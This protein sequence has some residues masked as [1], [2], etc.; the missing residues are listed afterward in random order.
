MKQGK[1]FVLSD[2]NSINSNGYRI[3]VNGLDLNRFKSNPVMLYEHDSKRVIGRW[4]DIKREDQ[5][6]TAIPEFDTEDTEVLSI[7]GKVERGFLN[8]VSVGII[9]KEVREIDGI[10][11]VTKSELFEASIV[12]VP[13]D[14]C[15][16]RL[17]NENMESLTADRLKLSITRQKRVENDFKD[18][19]GRICVGLELDKESRIESVLSAIKKV[20]QSKGESE[21]EQAGKLN[22]ITVAEEKLYLKLLRN[23]QT[24]VLNIV[25]EKRAEFE[26][27]QKNKLVE[28]YNQ[29]SDKILS[30]LTGIGWNEVKKSGYESAKK[31]VDCFPERI[32]LSKMIKD[33]NKAHN[34]DW[35]RKNN[36]KALRDNPELYQSLL[37]AYKNNK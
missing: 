29:N 14:A 18:F 19:Y 37:R 11:A 8:G 2:G 10:P 27:Q 6:L 25:A 33:G 32:F 30:H 34:L 21:I 1:R 4:A 28:L 5:K 7:A 24:D 15:A 36:P 16:V 3:D 17:Y 35:Y 12:S 26:D 9:V 23:G 22:I 13:A 31:I 20:M